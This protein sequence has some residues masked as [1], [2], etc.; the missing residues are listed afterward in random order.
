VLE[1]AVHIFN[2]ELVRLAVREE[3]EDEGSF[4]VGGELT[5]EVE[6]ELLVF[7][8]EHLVGG[9]FVLLKDLEVH[10]LALRA[11]SSVF[12]DCVK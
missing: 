6:F 8:L 2:G 5:T 4:V 11:G 7:G 9:V 10:K 1:E 3:N 12:L